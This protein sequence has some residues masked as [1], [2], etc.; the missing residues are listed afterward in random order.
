MY[1]KGK[2]KGY[3]NSW[4]GSKG[5]RFSKGFGFGKGGKGGF[6]STFPTPQEKDLVFLSLCPLIM[7]VK[8]MTIL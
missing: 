4:G 2:G 3:G 7:I 1:G 6:G 5:S 8:L